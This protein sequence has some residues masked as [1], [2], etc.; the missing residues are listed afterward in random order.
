M[1]TEDNKSTDGAVVP[2]VSEE[3]LDELMTGADT[4]ETEL[5][6]PDGLLSQ[7]TKAVLERALDEELTDHLGYD[8]RDPVGRGSGNS[9]NGTSPK[10]LLTEAGAIDL[11]IP[12]DRNGDFEPLIVPKGTTRLKRFQRSHHF[13]V[14]PWHDGA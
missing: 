3:V 7:V 11:A 4:S 14:C 1:S 13:V 6:G 8:K 10:V 12:R 2:L 5:L 9:R